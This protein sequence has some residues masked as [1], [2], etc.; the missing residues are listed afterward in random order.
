MGR[1]P[2]EHADSVLERLE[3]E[4]ADWF[5]LCCTRCFA[6]FDVPKSNRPGR[7]PELCPECA[8]ES[9]RRIR[10]EVY[11]RQKARAAA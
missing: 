10:R 1:K 3:A 9:K 8:L 2:G 7:L 5:V 4:T 11:A 6:F